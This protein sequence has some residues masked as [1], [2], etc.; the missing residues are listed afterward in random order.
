MVLLRIGL[1]AYFVQLLLGGAA[2]AEDCTFAEVLCE[3]RRAVFKI[4]AYD[5][6]ASAVRIGERLLVTNR[7]V[8]ADESSVRVLLP[9]GGTVDGKA[10]PTSYRGDLI[11]IEVDLPEGPILSPDKDGDPGPYRAIGYDLSARAVTIYEAGEALMQ[12]Q[13]GAFARLQHHAKT[14]TGNSGGALID[15]EGELVGI[16]ASGGEGR[17]EA[18]PVASLKELQAQSGPDFSEQS[19]RI[20]L[21]YRVCDEA[22]AEA[23]RT[24]S[25]MPEAL[26]ARLETQCLASANP[27]LIQLAAQAFGQ[28]GDLERSADLF[29]TALAADPNNINAR[30]G[31]ATTLHLGGRFADEVQVLRPLLDVIPTDATLQRLAL[32]AGKWGNAPDLAKQALQLIARYNPAQAEAAQRFYEA[33]L[34]PPGRVKPA[35]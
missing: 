6:A 17:S 7:H 31:Y 24:R 33:K 3:A 20:G 1:V 14:G 15:H 9:E 21:A 12:P 35:P 23:R 27:V 32:Q 11:L 34:P 4:E 30:M 19:V 10:V 22:L 2:R 16:N 26:T 18:I 29:V 8:V 25:A 5:P 13:Q 28:R